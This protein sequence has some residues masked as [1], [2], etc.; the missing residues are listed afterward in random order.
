MKHTKAPW[1][2]ELRI[3]GRWVEVAAR[4]RKWQIILDGAAH[5]ATA[6]EGIEYRI[7]KV[8]QQAAH[9]A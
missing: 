9:G 5:V 4:R 2:L 6:D 3:D 1:R 7:L 8:V